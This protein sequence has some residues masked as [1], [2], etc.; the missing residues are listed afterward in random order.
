MNG[1]GV[2]PVVTID[3]PVGSGKG[4]IA[5]RVA[6]ALGWHLL[7]SGALY[8]LVPLAADRRDVAR[9]DV[10]ALVELARQL[11]VRFGSDAQGEEQ[12]WLDSA[13]TGDKVAFGH[14]VEAYLRPV[15]NLTYRMLGNPQ[16]AEDAAQEA[17]VEAY[18]CLATLKVPPL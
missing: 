4:T 15:Y 8:R 5:R 7:D 18:Q 10:E 1:Q 16:E 9:D 2:I 12:I 13:R 11:D 17:F 3:G 6:D 14:L